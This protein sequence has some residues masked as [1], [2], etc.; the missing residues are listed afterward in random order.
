MFC[1]KELRVAHIYPEILAKLG[2][3]KVR[4]LHVCVNNI[5]TTNMVIY[6]Y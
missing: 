2:D 5:N 4:S 1:F 3:K 6:D